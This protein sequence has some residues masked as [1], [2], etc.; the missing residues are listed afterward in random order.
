MRAAVDS[1]GRITIPA[2]I[3]REFGIRQGDRIVM[4][5]CLDGS[6][7]VRVSRPRAG[8]GRGMF[9]ADR[10]F[11]DE[12]IDDAIGEYVGERY[13]RLGGEGGS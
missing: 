8:A 1:R 5:K 10:S 6:L 11:T 13:R 4:F 7:G 9:K 3:R 12:E 2:D